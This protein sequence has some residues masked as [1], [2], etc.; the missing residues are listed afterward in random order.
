MGNLLLSTDGNFYG[1]TSSG[2]TNG[3]GTVFKITPTGV[4]TV[5]KN[6]DYYV[7]GGEPRGSLVRATDG[8]FYGITYGGGSSGGGTIF[9]ITPA[10]VFTVIKPLEDLGYWF[11]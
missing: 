11:G 8:N 7:T 1:V 6:F 4:L 3:S 2:G 5:L 10:G 9:K